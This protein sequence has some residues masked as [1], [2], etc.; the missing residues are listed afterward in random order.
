MVFF[1][2]KSKFMQSKEPN[3]AGFCSVNWQ[4]LMKHSHLTLTLFGIGVHI[5]NTN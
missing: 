4:T 1:I 2:A 5:V 3:K